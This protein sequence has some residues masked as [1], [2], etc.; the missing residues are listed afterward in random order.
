MQEEPLSKG[1]RT[2]QAVL[3][4]AYELFLENGYAATSAAN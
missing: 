4:A 2:R 3:Q 1:E